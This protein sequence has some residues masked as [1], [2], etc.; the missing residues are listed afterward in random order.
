MS[1]SRIS[2]IGLAFVLSAITLIGTQFPT[3]SA[4]AQTSLRA[5]IDTERDLTINGSVA[6]AASGA[7]VA[8]GD[9]N[10]DGVPDLIVGSPFALVGSES[11]AGQVHVLFGPFDGAEIDLA[12]N[13]DLVVS[14]KFRFDG[15]GFGVASGDLND[16]GNDDLIIGASGVD[17]LDENIPQQ[18][19]NI[20]EVY[21]FFGPITGGEKST[22]DADVVLRGKENRADFGT[23]I[24]VGDIDDDGDD[25][26]AVGYAVADPA[27]RNAAG[28]VQIFFG[29]IHAP[30]SQALSDRAADLTFNGVDASDNA[31]FRVAIGDVSGDDLPDLIIGAQGGD[32]DSQR[33][34][35]GE[36]YV[37]YGPIPLPGT[38][39]ERELSTNTNVIVR[40][41]ASGDRSAAGVATGDVTG[42]GIGDLILSA[43]LASPDGRQSAGEVYVLEG[44]V[45][46]G[47][48]DSGL[49]TFIDIS[50]AA[51]RIYNGITANDRAGI[52]LA[53][54]D[55][56]NDDSP[57]LMIGAP[58]A[59]AGTVTGAGQTYVIF[60]NATSAPGVL[61]F[62][63]VH[64]DG[65]G[66]IDGL[67]GVQSVTV[68]VDG[69][70][71]YTAGASDSAV[72]VFSR[73]PTGALTFVEVHKD[74]I[75]GVDGLLNASSVTVS[76]DGK[77]LYATGYVDN[78]IA[79]FSR[80]STTG[81][82]T[83]VE[84]KK[85]GLDG[86]EGLQRA[87]SAIVSP[88]GKH[89]YVAGLLDDALAVFSRNSTTGALT[90]ME[91][92]RE[93]VGG[94]D[95]LVRP[96]SVTISPEGKHV[97]AGGQTEDAVVVFSRNSTTGA[98]TFVQVRKDGVDGVEGIDGAAS[99]NV[100]PDGKHLYVAGSNDDAVAVF[101]RDSTTGFLS[102][103][104]AQRDG[105]DGVYGLD[106]VRSV[107]VDPD[108]NYLYAAGHDDNGVAVLSRNATTGA[109]TFVEVKKGGVD[110]VDGL[111]GAYSVTVSPDGRHVYAAGAVDNSVAVF[112]VAGGIVQPPAPTI[113]S[114]LASI[115]PKLDGKL[116]IGEWETGNKLQLG[117]GFVT[118]K[119]DGRRLYVLLDMIDDTG[120]DTLVPDFFDLSFDVNN[121]GQI[122]P[123]VDVNYTLS[124][125][126]SN[127]RYQHY[128]SAGAW[129]S[130]RDSTR[131]ARAQGFGCFFADGSKVANLFNKTTTC[132]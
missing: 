72:A 76:P 99:V 9:I 11:G 116:G 88:D 44:P 16:D 109:L 34:N 10:G 92:Q 7:S 30:Q 73:D 117:N 35:A 22:D 60:G 102:Y 128:L 47:P 108:G 26:L 51:D 67:D 89:L 18:F 123:N 48:S 80:N 31:G 84:V 122:T 129:T 70:H 43:E 55:V 56:N 4:I 94:V 98:L 40:G 95:G 63:E 17:F 106:S 58:Q 68:S 49:E 131:S 127:M 97:Y 13:A 12:A 52:G 77:H 28:N 46:N 75:E 126:N 57:D 91:V 24:A 8:T 32:P 112:S 23:G 15:L 124:A 53:V 93:G 105:V 61:T 36:T 111:G 65:F 81:I 64:K 27:G 85:D 62:V 37:V 45:P 87:I 78:A 50:V 90:F 120:D 132:S 14:G 33:E 1:S 2:R 113:N 71:V 29:P 74:G 79:V 125:N 86:V 119:N 82:L 114:N 42:D 6:D 66:G 107:M 110:G 39:I 96:T 21:V 83:F 59:T 3:S 118:V 54:G 41:I 121:D 100:S 104:E 19:D 38:A 25:D 115:V 101:R 130:L 69:K 103:V 5:E 20:G